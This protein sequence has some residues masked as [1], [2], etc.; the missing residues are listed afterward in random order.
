MIGKSG[1]A[2]ALALAGAVLALAWALAW[3]LPHLRGQAS[4]LDWAEALLTDLRLQLS[5]PIA[6]PDDIVIVAIDDR[7]LAPEA[8][9]YPLGRARLAD[10]IDRIAEARPKLLALDILLVD[11]VGA[12]EDAAVA[13]ALGRVP[14][15]IAM[16]GSFA[17][18][19]PGAAAPQTSAELWP[20]QMFADTAAV[21]HVNIAQDASGSPRHVPLVLLTSRGVVP[22]LVLEAA[23]HFLGTPARLTDRSVVIGTLRHDLD[24]G[25]HLPLR[26]AGPVGTIRTLSAQ[27]LLA[28]DPAARRLLHGKLVVLGFTAS[29]VGDTF[30]SPFAAQ[31]PGVEVLAAGIAT[32]I[33]G[34]GLARTGTIR[35]IDL[36]ATVLLAVAG[37]LAVAR[38]RLAIGLP[39]ALLAVA[40]WLA[41]GLVLFSNGL[42][43][44]AALPL[45]GAVPPVLCMAVARQRLEQ[46]AALRLGRAVAALRV[47][48]PA[49]LADRIADDPNFLAVP[50]AQ[51]LAIL[52]VDLT[53]FTRISEA[54]GPD[55][56]RAFLKQ[57][58]SCVLTVV[59]ARGGMVLNFLGDGAMAVFGLPQG[60]PDDAANALAAALALVPAVH[61]LELPDGTAPDL[62]VG[63]HFGDVIVSR[64]GHDRH[65]Q[66]TIS[67]DAVNLASRLME[68]ARENSAIIAVSS[69]LTERISPA[70]RPEPDER[71]RA[72]VRGR[73]GTVDAD[74]WRSVPPR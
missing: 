24:R 23:A 48:H 27:D 71:L 62:R 36:L 38:F 22:A 21:G 18:G 6:A 64:L 65:Q 50:V 59:E 52:F 26:L 44:G 67:G 13:A 55:R 58:H 68:I 37:V 33:G 74:L 53:G 73:A 4:L 8:G 46:R 43:L 31:T 17:P 1:P 30:P 15:L 35:V 56:T 72:A 45:I 66:V 5:G 9:G 70:D 10:I 49:A 54:L 14:S 20:L 57:L 2:A 63:V 32:L 34:P 60:R 28:G 42:W 12:L 29:A 39:L 11:P 69:E 51:G 40:V 47:F 41:A 16:A 3:A 25:F 7:T 61:G 19:P